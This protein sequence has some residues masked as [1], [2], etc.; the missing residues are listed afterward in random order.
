MQALLGWSGR[1]LVVAFRGTATMANVI[2]DAKVLLPASHMR[3]L[4]PIA[5]I[6]NM[7]G[8]ILSDWLL[9]LFLGSVRKRLGLGQASAFL[10]ILTRRSRTMWSVCGLNQAAC[11]N[12]MP[13]DFRPGE[14]PILLPEGHGC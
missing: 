11:I 4:H 7:D 10:Q 2:S 9:P 12:G 3:Q 5:E 8:Q 13:P 1:N 6:P 14:A